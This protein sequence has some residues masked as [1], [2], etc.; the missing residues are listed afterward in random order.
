MGIMTSYGSY[1][2]IRKPIIL[3]NVIIAMTNSTVSFVSGFAVWAIVGFLQNSKSVAAANTGGT[4]LVFIAY[5]VATL[6]M[7]GSAGWTFLLGLTLFLLGVDSAFSMVEA[8]STVLSDTQT[9]KGIHKALLALMLCLVG[10][11]ISALFCTNWGYI[12][13]DCIDHYLGNYLLLLVGILQCAGVGWAFEYEKTKKRSEAYANSMDFLL[14]GYWIFLF[15]TG[16]WS[17]SV[18]TGKYGMLAFM[19]VLSCFVLPL[20]FL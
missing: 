1:N 16:A 15:I 10:L 6:K 12:L 4:D 14:Y 20:S 5:P 3:D 7:Q 17:I 9:F 18:G 2:P 19:G 8:V 11:A 13:F